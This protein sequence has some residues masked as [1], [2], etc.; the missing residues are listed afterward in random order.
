MVTA[1]DLEYWHTRLA[2]HF[3]TLA[4]ERHSGSGTP[5]VFALEHGLDEPEIKAIAKAVR[6]QIASRG[7]SRKYR[8][9]WIVYAAELGYRYSGTEYWQTFEATTPGWMARGDRHWI[10]RSYSWFRDEYGGATP[11]GQWADWFTIICWP[12]THAVLPKDLQRQL[13]RALYQIRHSF[14]RQVFESP[15][16]LGTLIAEH[17]WTESSRF[18]NLAQETELVGQIAAALLMKGESGSDRL[19]YAPTLRRISEDLDR[20]QRRREW[21]RAA[22]RSWKER[23]K[24][25]GL[26]RTRSQTATRRR[27]QDA[28]AEVMALGIEP[29]LVLR[30]ADADGI[31]W[32]VSVEIPDLSG[33]SQ[34]FPNTRAVLNNSRCTVAGTRGRPIARGALLYGVR[35]FVLLRWPNPDEV[36][37]QFEQSDLDLEFLLRTECLLRPGPRWLFRIASDGLAYECKSLRVRAGQRYIVLIAESVPVSSEVVQPARIQCRGIDGV[38]LDLPS[39][40]TSR[41]EHVIRDLGLAQ[42]KSIEVWPAGLAAT[43]WDGEGQGEW[44]V[45][46]RPTLG[47]QS[48]HPLRTVTVSL[49]GQPE[50]ATRFTGLAPG[51]PHFVELPRMSLGQHT[52]HVVSSGTEAR[53]TEDA[54]HL[55]VTMRV[56]ESRPWRHGI[57]PA[58]PLAVRIDPVVPSLEELWDGLAEVEMIGPPGRQVNCT[59]ALLKRGGETPTARANMRLEL[60]VTPGQWKSKFA[61]RVRENSGVQKKYDGAF[62][63]RVTVTAG[64]LG[65]FTIWCERELTPLRWTLHE[66]KRQPIIRLIDDSGRPERPRVSHFSFRE[67]AAEVPLRHASQYEVPAPG[68]LYVATQGEFSAGIIVVLR[69][70]RSFRS[71]AFAQVIQSRQRSLRSVLDLIK[72]GGKWSTANT[73]GDFLSVTNRRKTLRLITQHVVDLIGGAGWARA[74]SDFKEWSKRDFSVLE[75]AVTKQR[76]EVPFARSLAREARLLVQ[77]S[78][79]ERVD[80]LT[81][82]VTEHRLLRAHQDDS[83]VIRNPKWMAEFALRLASNPGAAE[84]WAGSSLHAA[85]TNLME[86]PVIA[87]AAR[88]MVVR[89]DCFVQHTGPDEVYAGWRWP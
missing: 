31:S 37:L 18:R 3:D 24:I 60:P 2:S 73:S 50:S 1:Q 17:S 29:R 78:V 48:D 42:S 56:G 43:A 52:I 89:A 35:Q 8:L 59:I 68:G 71:L 34:R 54:G 26:A 16:I 88:L 12:I 9:P 76:S 44:V 46:E 6:A 39:A 66:R 51:T 67:P 21:L 83:S 45:D 62:G 49:D 74:E 38:L 81:Q 87:R 20:E 64:E 10:R 19:L 80:Q 84:D 22:R 5:P 23:V 7:P 61:S 75:R 58:G 11:K 55:Q 36:L 79:D 25:R 33:L 53:H 70:V 32:R 4:S 14:S 40:V 30:P 72:L 77:S 41:L 57:S 47:I 15:A 69:R 63:C 13:A 82:L 27:Q 85:V 86:A 65:A 28:R